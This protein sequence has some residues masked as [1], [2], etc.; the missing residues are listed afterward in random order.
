MTALATR[1]A[2]WRS[3]CRYRE[4]LRVGLPLMLSHAVV[5]VMEFTDRIFLSNY[6]LAAISAA[7]PAGI[8]ALVPIVLLSGISGFAG[9]FIAQYVGAGTPRHIGGVLW[10]AIYFSMLAGLLTAAL[11]GLAEPI[12]S[13]SG[14]APEVQR[15]EIVYFRILSLGA[16]MHIIGIGLAAFFTGRGIT[17]PVLAVNAAGM[18]FNVPLDYALIYGV[19]GFPELGIAGAAYAT[20]ASWGL[21]L[22][23]YAMLV[24]TP[25]NDR[26]FR[27]LRGLRPDVALFR[28]L[29]RFGVPAGLQA[30]VDILGFLFF[31]FI[32]GR[33]GTAELA[34]TN[35]V[36][37][38]NALA[39]MP[40][41]GFSLGVSTLVG[42][43][44]GRARPDHARAAIWSAV[45]LML[46]YT[47]L[48]DVLYIAWPEQLIALYVP[49]GREHT[50]F[51]AVISISTILLRIVS[52][53]VFM[54]ALYMIFAGALRGAGD[55]HFVMW[56]LA[57]AVVAAFV[58]PVYIL[59]ERLHFGIV[60][61][62]LCVL[63]FIAVLCAICL[64]RYVSGRWQ[65]MRLLEQ[66]P[67]LT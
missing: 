3:R 10:Q 1:I 42:Q 13:W 60:A 38:I 65:S 37:N 11:A 64:W 39:F 59:I 56:S 16:G 17:G 52:M 44:M 33:I 29:L 26:A 6:S 47:L 31:I 43:A 62:W 51:S 27:V 58:L 7:T 18:L 48:I 5:T 2:E 9:V 25:A 40:V 8:M 14:H 12:F 49:S 66:E 22:L 15:L 61:A 20:V 4:V 35:I 23:L 46:I 50:D 63:V 55:T 21:I 45:H 53:Y 57:A 67:P 24:F 41:Y 36:I 54:D 32:I 19:W 30:T 28:R 34:A